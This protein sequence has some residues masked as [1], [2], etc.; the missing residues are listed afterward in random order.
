MKKTLII[1]AISA[2]LSL[3]QTVPTQAAGYRRGGF[4]RPNAAGGYS[5]GSGSAFRGPNAAGAAGRAFASDG[6][7][8]AVAGSGRMFRIPGGGAG[9]AGLTTRTTDG[10]TTHQGA[11]GARGVNGSIFSQGS[12]SYNPQTGLT[13]N[14]QTTAQAYSG[15]SYSGSTSYSQGTGVTHSGSC[16]NAFGKV[17]ACPQR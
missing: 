3:L 13:A 4:V 16:T 8:N 1:T 5:G 10:T 7:G 11:F 6:Q 14:R 9:R 17:V 12:S 15:Q 2:A